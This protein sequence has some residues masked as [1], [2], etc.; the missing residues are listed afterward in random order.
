MTDTQP[1]LG[2]DEYYRELTLRNAGFISEA[3]QQ[4]LRGAVI[5]VAGCGSTGGSVIELLVRSGAERLILVDNGSYELNNANRQN[6]VH[7]DVGR[8]KVEVFAERIYQINPYLELD[9]HA[10][11]ITP[12]NVEELVGR[13][14]IVVDAVDV[15]GRA[16]LEMKFLLHQVCQRQR[17]AVVCGYDMAAAQYIPVF[18]Y[19]SGE[20]AVLDGLLTAEQVA[21][22]D[23]LQACTFLIPIEYIPEQM[24]DELERHQGGKDYT[25]QLG[26]AAHLF[27]T[28]AT[29]LI[30][31]LVN[32]RAV[33]NDLYVDVWDMIRVR[34]EQ[35]P[36]SK[37]EQGR[38]ALAEW[39]RQAPGNPD[40]R[41]LER[42]VA[43]YQAPR[44]PALRDYAE[45]LLD[46]RAGIFSFAIPNR[47]LDPA[48]ARQLLRFAFVHYAKVGFI[49]PQTAARQLLHAEPEERLSPDD[50][51]IVLVD[52]A[53]FS[54]LA[55]STLKGPV[56]RGPRFGDSARPAFGVE[57]A[58]GRDLYAPIGALHGVPVEQ[59]REVG[60]V[61]KATTADPV[62]SA[63][64]GLLLLSAYRKLLTDPRLG[65]TA[66][67]GDGE[68]DVT[69]RN[70]SFFGFKPIIL[71]AR[72]ARIPAEHLYA[73]RYQGREVY[74]F[75][76]FLNG[77]DQAWA[78]RVERMIDL[79]GE[80]FLTQLRNLKRQSTME[81]EA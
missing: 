31:D 66:V 44:L 35:A 71:P 63:K 1:T 18:D 61:T 6:M 19:R 27:G 29:A 2:A 7:A 74:P 12:D 49:N 20:L 33:R 3:E 11:G 42:S 34:D 38:Q 32:G 52:Q 39:K 40:G 69:L 68:R 45:H 47:L 13:A 54:L 51:H 75:W 43:H 17:K 77:M 41:F 53:D 23:P 21:T 8:A 36:R 81:I 78:D 59:V 9:T 56:A 79:D 48:L 60:R 72:E 64:A 22:L 26:I 14:D 76:L 57:T 46:E 16:G 5:L 28:L 80:D 55:Y 24:Y 4:Q 50:V 70:L 30:L 25:S 65:I 62:L 37:L 73:N 58:F 67:V 10:H 15:T